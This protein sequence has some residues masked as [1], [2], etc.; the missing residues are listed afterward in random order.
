MK[1]VLRILTFTA[2]V[3]TLALP[4][5]A[6]TTSG[7]QSSGTTTATTAQ[8]D[9][10][11]ADLYKKFLDN[12][13]G[14]AEKQKLAHEA[15]KEYIAKYSSDKSEDNVAI[16]TYIQ[17]WVTKYE[18]VVREFQLNQVVNNTDFTK[19]V[20]ASRP[21]L[22]EEPDSV[23][24]NLALANI[25]FSNFSTG[26]KNLG[27]DTL[28][29]TR[30]AIQLIESGRGDDRPETW[31]AFTKRDEAL[32]RL[33][34]NQGF[35]L[36]ETSPDEAAAAFIKSAQSNS[37]M[38]T[39]AA[40]Y[41]YLGNAIRDGEYARLAAEYKAKYEG[42]EETE[43]SKA[44][45]ARL[46]QLTDRIIDAW[47]RAVALSTKPEEQKFK[48]GLMTQ[49]TAAYKGRHENSDAGLQ[50]LIAS[51]Q[52]RP[53]PLPGAPIA[54]PAPTTSTPTNGTGTPA[55]SGAAPAGTSTT[56]TTTAKPAAVTAKPAAK[57]AATTA[58]PAS[59][60]PRPTSKTSTQAT[61]PKSGKVASTTR[62]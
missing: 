47:A 27:P 42:K 29:Y 44:A 52:S 30:R 19:A 9:Q 37:S 34:Y 28:N 3:A 53:L 22:R 16:V 51:V 55:T 36:L 17:N 20:E 48:A 45:L 23:R 4:A 13:T 31:G 61:K 40:T 2:I 41:Y 14:D 58:T 7:S 38:K 46:D 39:L 56:T 15:G 43:E 57:P 5:F 49:L 60:T 62:P 32:G 33:Y 8:D 6:Q 25:G 54:T 24:I 35:L 12:R 21:F 10:A 59:T 1:N 18:Q 11:K 26:K 50:Q